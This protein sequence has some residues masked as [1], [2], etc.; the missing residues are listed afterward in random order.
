MII[1]IRTLKG[2][3]GD[4]LRFAEEVPWTFSQ[5]TPQIATELTPLMVEGR[6][7]NTGR[8][9]YVEG[10]LHIKVRMTCTRCLDDY[11]EVLSA[12]FTEEYVSKAKAAALAAEG[13]DEWPDGVPTYSGDELDL[14]QLLWDTVMLAVPMKT[15]CDA[16]CKGMC[17]SCGE[18]LNQGHCNC[19]SHRTDPRLASLADLLKE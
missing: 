10:S 16:E 4:F 12:A 9:M 8:A 15:I 3:K 14:H 17:P 7:T 2:H 18:S 6:V 11:E 1:T 19:T 5:E 13:D